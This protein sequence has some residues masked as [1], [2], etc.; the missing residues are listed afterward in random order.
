M[1]NLQ[2]TK[3]KLELYIKEELNEPIK[4][5]YNFKYKN[6]VF[7]QYYPK[8]EFY[9]IYKEGDCVYKSK[10]LEQAIKEY[11]KIIGEDYE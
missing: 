6:Q 2:E 5:I 1:N 8:T 10:N 9:I 11:W 3:E 4:L 7:F